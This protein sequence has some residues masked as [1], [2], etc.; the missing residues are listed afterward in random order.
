[1][2]SLINRGKYDQATRDEFEHLVAQVGGFLGQIFDADGQI[3]RQ[4]TASMIRRIHH[5]DLAIN[6]GDSVGYS[7]LP[8][9][10]D[11]AKAIVIHNGSA[12][13][14]TRIKFDSTTRLIGQRGGTSGNDTID[15]IVVEYV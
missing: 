13:T 2:I 14:V 6:N 15:Y 7:T 11:L 3:I 5:G 9:A 12:G 10:V 4:E 8:F 1:M